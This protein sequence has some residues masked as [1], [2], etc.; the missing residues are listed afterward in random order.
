[1]AHLV[2]QQQIRYLDRNGRRVPK[3]TACAKKVKERSAKW[4][5]AGIPGQ[6]TRRVPLASDKEAAQRMLNELVRAAERGEARMLD[7]AAVAKSLKEHLEDFR[8]E[9]AAGVQVST[10]R[11]RRTPPS[12]K[13]VKTTVQRVRDVLDGCGFKW[14]DDL[15]SPAAADRLS[16]YLRDRLGKPRNGTDRGI[17]AQTATFLLADA[18][19]FARWI[20]RRGTGVPPDRFD[21]IAGFDAANERTHARREVSPDE[22]AK[23]LAAARD[24]ER[25]YR[26]LSGADRYHLYLTAFATGFRK[27]ELASLTPAHFRLGDDSPTVSLP[28][29]AAKN[30]KAVRHPLPPGVAAALRD[31]LAGR[32]DGAPVWPGKW[33]DSS[34]AMLRVDLETAG[35]PYCVEGIHGREY[36]DFHALRH[37]YISA[38]SA[39]GT[40]MKELQVL[41]RHSDPRLTL[42]VYSHARSTELVRAVGRLKV[43]GTAE[44]LFAAL[45]REQLE[46]LVGGLLV[47]LGTLLGPSAAVAPVTPRVTLP[48]GDSGDREGLLGPTG[49]G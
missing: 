25:G 2:R 34:A 26:G 39:A 21:A 47:L 42:G 8:A 17:S 12:A 23:V 27:S 38:L 29:K 19:R 46:D 32:P 22:L 35:V 36:A 40:G 16:R 1:M 44:S 3:G 24:S 33:G 45:D 4:Y 11:K 41:A 43:P 30:R 18:R 7:R 6:G 49:R 28:G 20:A 15:K 31:Y 10:G 14:I 9:L 48:L 13:Q 37:S 5:G